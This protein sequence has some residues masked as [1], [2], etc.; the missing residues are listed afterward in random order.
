[1]P[2]PHKVGTPAR[3]Q[4]FDDFL[5]GVQSE[6]ER[7]LLRCNAAAVGPDSRC[8]SGGAASFQDGADDLHKVVEAPWDQL[9]PAEDAIADGSTALA[10]AAVWQRPCTHPDGLRSAP[11]A[12]SVLAGPEGSGLIVG[13]L[14]KAPQAKSDPPGQRLPLRWESEGW[15]ETNSQNSFSDEQPRPARAETKKLTL[16]GSR[17]GTSNLAA[18]EVSLPVSNFSMRAIKSASTKTDDERIGK[19]RDLF[20]RIDINDDGVISVHEMHDFLTSTNLMQLSLEELRRSFV[21]IATDKPAEPDKEPDE[22]HIDFEAF[23][24]IVLQAPEALT[25]LPE[26]VAADFLKLRN[27]LIRHDANETLQ[28]IL[29]QRPRASTVTSQN[30]LFLENMVVYDRLDSCIAV[31]IMIN[32]ITIGWGTDNPSE[33]L[34][35][36][37]HTFNGL[38]LLEIAFKLRVLGPRHYFGG[39]DRYW[40]C[41]DALLCIFALVDVVLEV[42]AHAQGGSSKSLLSMLRLVRLMRL[43]RVL[44]LLRYR[45]FSELTLMVKGVAAGCRTLFWAIVLLFFLVYVFSLVLRQMLADDIKDCAIGAATCSAKDG[46]GMAKHLQA[47]SI[48]QLMGTVPRTMFT[49]FRCFAGDCSSPE[50]TPVSLI[51]YDVYEVGFVLPYCLA[52]LFVTFGIFNMIVAIFV[53][54]VLEAARQ[55]RRM[56]AD[57]ESILLG[58]QL[59]RLLMKFLPTEDV[60]VG[61]KVPCW[62][63]ALKRLQGLLAIERT[64]KSKGYS[65]AEFGMKIDRAMFV[66]VIRDEEVKGILDDLD[67]GSGDRADFFDVI[68]ADGSGQLDVQELVVGLS[69]LRGG[70]DKSD[71][72]ASLLGVRALQRL[73]R[74][75]MD[76]VRDNFEVVMSRQSEI[77]DCLA[78]VEPHVG[79][80]RA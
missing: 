31:V 72:V 74:E 15:T 54:T 69:K 37:E 28:D 57:Q 80:Q 71:V 46:T 32:A 55:K 30:T 39:P 51:L 41:F 22:D 48:D 42:A 40:H 12:D 23:A 61:E 44:R 77:L 18:T 56:A 79:G 17:S 63:S 26:P 20:G 76:G 58:Q 62:S 19:L 73:L 65:G 6:Y 38:Y 59:Q 2:N 14:P 75:Y 64:G 34:R 7:F 11:T 27:S 1:M 3:L 78:L 66:K 45:F 52:F 47:D 16:P 43:Q 49:V 70:A 50:G 25:I 4:P 29:A 53:E 36:I 10:T 60:S 68:D 9:Q 24:A 35:I 8:V 33:T 21:A 5:A 67:I 13:E